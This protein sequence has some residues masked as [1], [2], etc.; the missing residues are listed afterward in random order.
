M[1][2]LVLLAPI[3]IVLQAADGSRGRFSS[4]PGFLQGQDAPAHVIVAISGTVTLKRMEWT[5]YAPATFGMT[6]KA[7]DLLRLQKGARA[8]I[9]C[10][11]LTLREVTAVV[12]GVPCVETAPMLVY[13]GSLL[14]A[15]RSDAPT[16]GPVLISP[17]AT[18]LLGVRPTIRWMASDASTTATVSVTGPGVRWSAP[19]ATREFVYPATAPGLIRGATYRV[20][21][22]AG[23]RSSD[24]NLEPGTGFTPVPDAEARP[25]VEAE[26]A[27]QRL[28]LSSQSRALVT[29][30]LYG[31]HGLLAEAID[32]LEHLPEGSTEPAVLRE[33]AGV[34]SRC[35]VARLSVDRYTRALG[36]FRERRDV[37]GEAAVEYALGVLYSDVFGNGGR[38]ADALKAALRLYQR[39]G[40]DTTSKEIKKRLDDL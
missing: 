18:R 2:R 24:D 25:I 32:A 3:L 19:V 6:L 31:S 9:V 5:Q 17:R 23:G 7:G 12:S 38:A 1:T 8:E 30:R 34:Y 22:T 33:L 16:E 21:I 20:V 39:L 13:K 11:D 15:T 37:D 26:Q 35:G 4:V 36:L 10:A 40:D 29:A 28:T 27:I 14:T